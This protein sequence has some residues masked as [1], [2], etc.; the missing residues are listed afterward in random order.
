M[1]SLLTTERAGGRELR[2]TGGPKPQREGRSA[3]LGGLSGL[4]AAARG[5][6]GLGI[7]LT[8]G[9]TDGPLFLCA[10][11]PMPLGRPRTSPLSSLRLRLLL[12]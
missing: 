4:P 12:G 10:A 7:I 11:A 3:R 9:R 6:V 5:A 2:D 1:E 8:Y